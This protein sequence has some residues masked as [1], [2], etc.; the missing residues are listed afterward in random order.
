M[1]KVPQ[2]QNLFNHPHILYKY[3]PL[4]ND[5][6]RRAKGD[7]KV[8]AFTPSI[9]KSVV[10]DDWENVDK[11]ETIVFD[12]AIYC[13]SPAFFNDPFDTALPSM[14]DKVPTE[15]ERKDIISQLSPE[16]H[17]TFKEMKELIDEPDFEQTITRLFNERGVPD[18][19][20]QQFIEEN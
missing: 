11:W 15:D 14:P 19:F 16:L 9:D 10:W 18:D 13:T 20:C 5:Y 6:A 3:Y 8:L 2:F 4:N 17:F 12:G 1:K 7:A